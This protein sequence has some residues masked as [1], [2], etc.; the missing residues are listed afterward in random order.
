M[1]A[2]AKGLV[3]AMQFIKL[4]DGHLL[5]NKNEIASIERSGEGVLVHLSNGRV[6]SLSGPDAIAVEQAAGETMKPAKVKGRIT[7]RF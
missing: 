7:E 5:I 6:Y 1:G 4:R 2:E 3:L